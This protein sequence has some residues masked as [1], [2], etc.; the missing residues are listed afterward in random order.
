MVCSASK[1]KLL[2]A[3]TKELRDSKLNGVELL[4]KVDGKN[5]WKSDPEK[6]LGITMSKNMSWNVFLYGNKDA[7][8]NRS[9]GLMSQLSK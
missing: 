2:V 3:A 4:V 7:G 6:L 1:T 9:E 8:A 5:I